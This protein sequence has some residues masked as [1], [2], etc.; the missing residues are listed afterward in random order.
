KDWAIVDVRTME[1][2]QAAHIPGSIRIGRQ[3]GE[4][5][6]AAVVTDD[7]DNFTKPNI[8][9]VCNTASRASIE[10]VTLKKLG[11]KTVKIYDIVSWMDECN[12]VAN[13][14]SKKKDKKGTKQKF[15]TYKVAHCYK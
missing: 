2:Y 12:P 7:N 14:Y 10:A 13:M 6:I 1:E 3:N 15:G 4:K 11:F 8:V 9:V 5:A